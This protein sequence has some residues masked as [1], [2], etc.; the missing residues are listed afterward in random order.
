MGTWDDRVDA[1]WDDTGLTD[2][3][4]IE[5][6]DR[7]A[8]ERD[9]DDARALFERAG[10]RD[11]AGQEAGA[12]PLY[13]AALAGALD[14]EHRS[15]AVIQL[16][17]TLRNLGRFDEALEMLAAERGRGGDL[18]DAASAF[19]AL[20]LASRGDATRA[21]AVALEALA[22]HLPRYGRAVRAYAGNSPQTTPDMPTANSAFGSRR[23]R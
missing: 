2:A 17:S 23:R 18:A 3:E 11:S 16:A 9:A 19:Y 1:V 22:P 6:I 12:E 8:T 21:A 15:Q 4:R 10:A 20:T 5:A 7:L 13:R 14:E